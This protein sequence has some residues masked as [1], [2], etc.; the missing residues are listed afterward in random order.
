MFLIVFAS[1]PPS[2]PLSPPPPTPSLLIFLL[3]LSPSRCAL[4]PSVVSN[5]LQPHGL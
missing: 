1:S 5:S 2:P 4:S 3:S